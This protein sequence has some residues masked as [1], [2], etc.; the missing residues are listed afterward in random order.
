MR[1]AYLRD[2]AV[3]QVQDTELINLI[4]KGDR[5]AFR[6]LHRRYFRAVSRFVSRLVEDSERIE[7]VTNDTMLAIWRGAQGFQHR[8]KVST[9]IFGIAYRVARKTSSK[10]RFERMHIELDEAPELASD[11]RDGF[12]TVFTKQA[13]SKALSTLSFD[14]RAV[15]ELTYYYGLS[16]PEISEILDCPVGTV[17][18]RM[19]AAREK[20]RRVLS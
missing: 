8:S 17:K 18:S 3:P 10:Y 12:E 14:L 6:E 19:H 5:G 13:L 20:L 1:E 15:V 2:V 4:A 7:E 9:W 11:T 16:Y